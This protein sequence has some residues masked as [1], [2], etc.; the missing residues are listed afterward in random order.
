MKEPNMFYN[1]ETKK[2]TYKAS[3]VAENLQLHRV[4]R[5]F[6]PRLLCTTMHLMLFS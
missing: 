6:C 4:V 2:I 5:F 3:D 1:Y